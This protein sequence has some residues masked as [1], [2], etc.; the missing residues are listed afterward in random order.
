MPEISVIMGVCN[1]GPFLT[2]TLA[3]LRAQTFADWELVL[4]DNGSTDYA[5]EA[6]LAAEP[7]PRVRV[8]RHPRPLSAGGALDVACQE[9]RGRYLAVLDADDLARPQRLEIQRAYLDLNPGTGLLGTAS[10]LIDEQGRLLGREPC[11]CRHEDIHALVAYVHVLRHSS[12]M[13]RRELLERV[14]YR[15]ATGLAADWDFFART[16]EVTRLE[17]LPTVL[18]QYR[19]HARNISR[20]SPACA[21]DRALVAMATQ[22]R[23]RGLPEEI[24]RWAGVFGDAVAS[25]DGRTGRAYAATAR[26]FAAAGLYDLAALHAWE[27]MRAGAQIRGLWV[28]LGTIL[29][30]LGRARPL[31]AATVRAWLKEPAHQ[32]LRAGGAPDRPQF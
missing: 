12:V 17:V 15:A 32:L 23:R 16:T 29:R 14:R 1:G 7:D 18:C 20:E 25:A 28:Y 10:D 24:E 27:A 3:S 6:A 4:V 22:R 30:G 31:A 5:V 2:P 13:F 21:A 19:L 9:A 8:F 26:V 11:V